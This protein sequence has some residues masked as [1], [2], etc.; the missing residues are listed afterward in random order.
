[1]KSEESEVKKKTGLQ[2]IFLDKRSCNFDNSDVRWY[3]SGQ[4]IWIGKENNYEEIEEF[5]GKAYGSFNW[6]YS[7]ADTLIFD[8]DTLEFKSGIFKVKEPVTVSNNEIKNVITKE[9]T[10]ALAERKNTDCELCII[11]KYNPDA[12][13]LISYNIK[14][15][16]KETVN[17]FHIT[18]DFYFIINDDEPAGIVL[19]NASKHIVKDDCNNVVVPEKNNDFAKS[20]LEKYLY[21]IE[22]LNADIE[23]DEEALKNDFKLLLEQIQTSTIQSVTAI[24]ENIVSILDYM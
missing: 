17:V 1:M 7:S 4:E 9:G 8:K 22:R 16:F 12:D 20:V 24:R 2:V 15:D 13:T 3:L 6:L 18:D 23:S 14:V 11:S 21:L 19:K 5:T 10:I